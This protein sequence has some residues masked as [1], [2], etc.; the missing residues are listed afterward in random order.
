MVYAY[1]HFQCFTPAC[2][3]LKIHLNDCN[4]ILSVDIECGFTLK[5]VRDMII[6]YSQLKFIF[7]WAQMHY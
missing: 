2:K 4:G 1:A 5:C 6:I 3:K 7:L